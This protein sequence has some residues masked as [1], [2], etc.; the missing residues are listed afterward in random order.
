MCIVWSILTFRLSWAH[1]EGPS[2][3][4]TVHVV[5]VSETVLF[6]RSRKSYSTLADQ[7]PHRPNSRP[8]PT[9][10]PQRDWLALRL[11]LVLVSVQS[12]VLFGKL[13]VRVPVVVFDA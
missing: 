13:H 12:E 3:R 10:Q 8:L 7:L 5:P 4:L 6:P 9:T 1:D 11:E 2:P